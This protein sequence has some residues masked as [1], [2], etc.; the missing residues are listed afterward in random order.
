MQGGVAR[1][2]LPL[3]CNSVTS[4]VWVKA[5]SK[6]Q[7]L[8]EQTQQQCIKQCSPATTTPLSGVEERLLTAHYYFPH[9][10]PP[11]MPHLSFFHCGALPQRSITV[12]FSWPAERNVIP[13]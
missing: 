11:A 1:A 13:C 5:S 9:T 3:L 8:A 7:Q 10:L 12:L 2:E 6:Q 4:L